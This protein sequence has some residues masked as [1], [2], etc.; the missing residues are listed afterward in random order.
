MSTGDKQTFKILRETHKVSE[1]VKENLKLFNK[2]K[3]LILEQLKEGE[4]SIA[5]IS[6][7]TEMSKRDVVFYL[8]SLVKYGM[9]VN[10]RID[11]ND[12]YYYYKLK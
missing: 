1:E 3:R 6:A 12:E 9:V 11:D 8:M 5:E 2:S 7:A 10:S 4:K